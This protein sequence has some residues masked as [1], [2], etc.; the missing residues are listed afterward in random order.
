[1]LGVVA[2]ELIGLIPLLQPGGVALVKISSVLLR[3]ARLRDI[4][5]EHVVEAEVVIQRP[6]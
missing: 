6:G 1:M 2:D 4:S 5:D 3:D